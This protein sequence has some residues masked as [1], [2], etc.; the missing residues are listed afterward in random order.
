MMEEK[1]S[2]HFDESITEEIKYFA[3]ETALSQSRYIFVKKE[4]G[5]YMGYCSNC[6][7]EFSLYTAKHKDIEMCPV[8]K[9][10]GQI[11]M[12]RYGRRYLKDAACFIRYDKS[13]IDNETLVARA[14][15]VERDYSGDYK[16]VNSKF[17]ELARYIFSPTESIMF[18]KERWWCSDKQFYYK[19]K[20]FVLEN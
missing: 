17:Q 13:K 8:C 16:N 19:D 3:Y 4:N 6:G 20:L 14:F 10:S 12:I 11:R 9:C 5:Q 18:E 7:E 1:Y 15:L 2:K